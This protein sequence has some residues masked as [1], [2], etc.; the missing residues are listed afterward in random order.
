MCYM[1]VISINKP[2]T[3][4]DGGLVALPAHLSQWLKWKC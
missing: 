3:H 4:T 1:K 2:V